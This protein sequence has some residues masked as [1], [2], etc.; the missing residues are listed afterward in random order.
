M[1]M[2]KSWILALHR[3]FL[4]S[5]KYLVWW[6]LVTSFQVFLSKQQETTL[7]SMW[8]LLMVNPLP[9]LQHWFSTNKVNSVSYQKELHMQIIPREGKP[10]TKP[11]FSRLSWNSVLMGNALLQRA[12]LVRSVLIGSTIQAIA[13][14]YNH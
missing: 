7:T 5:L 10:W 8:K 14:Q 13:S 9:M 3:K 2:W 6:F 4:R 1:T 11:A 12:L